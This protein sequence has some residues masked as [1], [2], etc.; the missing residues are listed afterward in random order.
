MNQQKNI[1]RVRHVVKIEVDLVDG[2][3]TV[4]IDKLTRICS[5]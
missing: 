5:F 4:G 1:K 2:M 3:L